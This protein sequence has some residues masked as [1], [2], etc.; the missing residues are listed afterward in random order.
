MVVNALTVTPLGQAEAAEPG[1]P[2]RP[3]VMLGTGEGYLDAIDLQEV[4][5][6]MADQYFRLERLYLPRKTAGLTE[7]N[8]ADTRLILGNLGHVGM[9]CQFLDAMVHTDALVAEA[10]LKSFYEY[11]A[12]AAEVLQ[13]HEA[14][15]AAPGEA[16]H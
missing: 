8:D 5:D 15:A 2:L 7:E 4:L 11:S 12:E 6:A 9:A 16:V 3:A 14:V 10:A 13:A 1:R